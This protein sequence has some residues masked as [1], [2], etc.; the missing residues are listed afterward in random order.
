MHA[1]TKYFFTFSISNELY[2]FFKKND[3]HF[4][5]S[6]TKYYLSTKN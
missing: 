6:Y 3:E 2:I 5:L 4:L 1:V